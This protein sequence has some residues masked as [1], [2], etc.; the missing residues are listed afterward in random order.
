MQQAEQI[1]MQI[2]SHTGYLKLLAI[3][4]PLQAQVVQRTK[5]RLETTGSQLSI[6]GG[7]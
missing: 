5:K 1:L 4:R 7:V 2:A 6:N 3:L